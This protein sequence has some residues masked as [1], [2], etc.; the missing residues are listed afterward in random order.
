MRF[1]ASWWER[2]PVRAVGPSLFAVFA[3]AAVLGYGS[4]L[5]QN[6]LGSVW[7]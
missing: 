2:I 6:I 7:G 3:G 4:P 1:F 5:F